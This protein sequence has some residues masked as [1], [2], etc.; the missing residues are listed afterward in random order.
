MKL[1][2]ER[3]FE[4]S[5]RALWEHKRIG[6][7]TNYTGVDRSFV[8]TV[9]RLIAHGADVVRLFSAEHGF[10]GVAQA[11]I[12]VDHEFDRRTGLEIVSL[13]GASKDVPR[14]KLRDLDVLMLEF[15]DVG[16]RFYTYI[17][18]MWKVMD[19]AEEVGLPLVVLDRP[20]PIGGMAIEGAGVSRE[21]RSFVG[22]YDLPIRHGMTMGEL[23]LFYHHERGYTVD[24][25]VVPMEGWQRTMHWPE[26]GLLW[27]PP[28]PNMPS[29]E[30]VVLYPGTGFFEGTNL[31]EGRGTAFPF[32][33]IGAP[34]IESE[35]LAEALNAL[36]LPGVR[37]RP[38]VFIPVY[39]KHRDTRVEGVHVHLTDAGAVCPT[40][41]G[42]KMI[43]VI[44]R[45]Y[46]NA[47]AWLEPH[48]GRYFIDL[49][50]GA[51]YYREAFERGRPVEEIDQEWQEAAQHFAV[52][53]QG[54]LLYV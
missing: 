5:Y 40:F 43:E 13:Y 4:P 32:Q 50:W 37:F 19:R 15:Q 7:V 49:L 33:W 42:L 51:P 28:S 21:M 34:W 22:A 17:S 54:F 45:L 11:G 30:A 3:L 31:S 18:T 47:F 35:R 26:T 8:R 46:P 25:T 1:G 20:N 52:R 39:S 2:S 14:D 24:L 53:R 29:Y 16:V 48:Q 9:D 6:L 12:H 41:L 44:R 38:I 23:A 27:V 36:D 10:Y